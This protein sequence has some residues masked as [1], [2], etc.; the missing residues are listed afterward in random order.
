MGAGNTS[1]SSSA[2][3]QAARLDPDTIQQNFSDIRPPLK[4]SEALIE[5]DRCYFCY[6][7]PLHYGLSDRH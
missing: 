4:H 6:D 5:A 1:V 2:R 7:A 3:V